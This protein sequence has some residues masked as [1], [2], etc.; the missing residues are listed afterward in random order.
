MTLPLTDEGRS[1]LISGIIDGRYIGY[2]KYI[3]LKSSGEDLA[4]LYSDKTPQEEREETERKTLGEAL[5]RL[6]N[7][8]RAQR[9][10][11]IAEMIEQLRAY[12]ERVK[13]AATLLGRTLC[14][15]GH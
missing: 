14:G 13:V 9:E 3:I 11:Q 12:L 15:Q 4:E 2:I 5:P 6:V 1:R 10:A 7:L 8:S